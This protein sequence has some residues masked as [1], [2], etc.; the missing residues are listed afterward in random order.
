MAQRQQQPRHRTHA[1]TSRPSTQGR[2]EEIEDIHVAC[3]CGEEC[4]LHIPRSARS[5]SASCQVNTTMMSCRRQSQLPDVDAQRLCPKQRVQGMHEGST[6]LFATVHLFKLNRT[7]SFVKH[8]G[9]RVEMS[10]GRL[11]RVDHGY[12][13]SFS[14]SIV[15]ASV[16]LQM[17]HVVVAEVS[18]HKKGVFE[19]SIEETHLVAAD[20]LVPGA[21]EDFFKENFDTQGEYNLIGYNCRHYCQEVIN[22]LTAVSETAVELA[23]DAA[24]AVSRTVRNDWAVVAAVTGV[25]VIVGKALWSATSTPQQRTTRRWV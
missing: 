16:F 24:T 25:M 9:F 23:S 5:S 18:A 13:H 22:K 6:E 19:S 3:E 20:I 12:G 1:S 2:D 21:L 7:T 8:T 10:D 14:A 17:G 15:D 11:F 4:V